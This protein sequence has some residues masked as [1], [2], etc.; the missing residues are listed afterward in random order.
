MKG[1]MRFGK[2][3]KLSLRYMGPYQILKHI[4][5]VAYE[6]DLPNE[7]ALIHLVF[8]VSMLKKCIGDPVSIL[9]LEGLGV[10][11][12]LFYKKVPVEILDRQVKRLR[13]KEVVSVKVLW[14]NHL[15]EG[16]T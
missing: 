4:G 13:N 11:E 5:K 16:A 7:L 10:D 8:H 9:P 2:K 1:V 3:G 12:K 15:V 14:R 6:L